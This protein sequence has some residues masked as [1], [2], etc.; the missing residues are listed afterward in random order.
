MIVISI[1][2]SMFFAIIGYLLT[3]RAIIVSKNHLST[4]NRIRFKLNM[5]EEKIVIDGK[6]YLI[7]DPH[8]KKYFPQD[9][10]LKYPALLH[11]TIGL[12]MY[13]L[14]L[15]TLVTA[16]FHCLKKPVFICYIVFIL[17]KCM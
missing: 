3:L 5:E 6:E 1:F 10:S 7:I 8:W 4:V 9:L 16:V 15:S 11:M 14:I 12:G 13:I 2:I 17:N